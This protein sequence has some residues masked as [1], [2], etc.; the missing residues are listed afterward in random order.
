M[1]PEGSLPRSQEPSTGPYPE[2]DRSS[3]SIPFH[4]ISLRSTLIL[5]THQRLGLHSGL[6]PSG[7]P[8][9]ILYAFLFS[10]ICATFPAHMRI[11]Y[12]CIKLSLCLT[13]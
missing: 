8:T 9:N 11:Q 5:S 3:Q 4:P 7:F 6:F 1:E 12:L 13:N 2:P 10:P